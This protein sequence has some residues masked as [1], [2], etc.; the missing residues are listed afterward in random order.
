MQAAGQKG[1][2][3]SAFAFW[4]S[5][6]NIL[7]VGVFLSFFFAHKN[8]QELKCFKTKSS[9]KDIGP[10]RLNLSGITEDCA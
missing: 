5:T 9:L 4:R 6:Q 7:E 8:P 2:G 3:C 1:E 10:R